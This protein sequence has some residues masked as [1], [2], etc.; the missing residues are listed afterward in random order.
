MRSRRVWAT[1]SRKAPCDS[2]EAQLSRR[3]ARVSSHS[4]AA[5]GAGAGYT[6]TFEPDLPR[7]SNFTMPSI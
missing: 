3:G 1:K 2:Q 6:L 7:R 5:A 4:A